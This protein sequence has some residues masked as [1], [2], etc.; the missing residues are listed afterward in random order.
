[1]NVAAAVGGN[2]SEGDFFDEQELLKEYQPKV[3]NVLSGTSS[4]KPIMIRIWLWPYTS[5][6]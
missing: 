3:M 4:D 6:N 1:M 5:F 2:P